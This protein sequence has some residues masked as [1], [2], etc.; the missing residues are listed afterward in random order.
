MPLTFFS[1]MRTRFFLSTG[2]IAHMSVQKNTRPTSLILL[3]C[4]L[5]TALLASCAPATVTPVIFPTY[6]PFLP[7]PQDTLLDSPLAQTPAR[8]CRQ[9]QHAKQPLHASINSLSTSTR[10]QSA[11]R[12][13]TYTR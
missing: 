9:L 8:R 10:R 13:F 5:I 11:S 2:K 7:I 3:S 6:D 4:L 1:L 12:K